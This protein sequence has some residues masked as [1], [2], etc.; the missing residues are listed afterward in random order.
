MDQD[1]GNGDDKLLSLGM[2]LLN[3]VVRIYDELDFRWSGVCVRERERVCVS[4]M[5]SVV[6]VC[7]CVCVCV[8]ER[9]RERE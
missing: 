3:R 8:S 1:G 2:Y 6:C 7:V 4:R 9:E 5:T